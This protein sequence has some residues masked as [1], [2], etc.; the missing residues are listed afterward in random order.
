MR[1]AQIRSVIRLLQL[2]G[3]HLIYWG[4]RPMAAVDAGNPGA[5]M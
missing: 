5:V 4:V 1:E 3:Q 2:V